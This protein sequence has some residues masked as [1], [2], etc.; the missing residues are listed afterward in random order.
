MIFAD[1]ALIDMVAKRP[2]T[3]DELSAV[4]GVGQRK[5][6]AYGDAFLKALAGAA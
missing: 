1:R 4:H 5:L 6:A 2:A 3:L